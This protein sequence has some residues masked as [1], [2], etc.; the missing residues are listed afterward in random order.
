MENSK[1]LS[2]EVRSIIDKLGTQIAEYGEAFSILGREIEKLEHFHIELENIGDRVQIEAANVFI[3]LETK[4]SNTISRLDSKSEV[5]MRIDSEWEAIRELQEELSRL[6]DKLRVGLL[7][8][9]QATET[10]K[11][12]SELELESTLN[13]IKMRLGK[14]IEAEIGKMEMHLALKLKNFDVKQQSLEHRTITMN[15]SFVREINAQNEDIEMVKEKLLAHKMASDDLRKK[16]EASMQDQF[17]A[18]KLRLEQFEE[19]RKKIDRIKEQNPEKENDCSKE[20]K[21]L[22]SALTRH[23]ALLEEL[24]KKSSGAM[25]AAIVGIA[26]AAIALILSIVK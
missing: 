8:L 11:T 10:F 22:R 26:V 6:Q 1:A 23:N 16:F 13:H 12:K 2:P 4:V 21:D 7:E 3:D 25:T 14:E 15:D 17:E 9:S 5:I 18:M 24:M 19:N 20:I